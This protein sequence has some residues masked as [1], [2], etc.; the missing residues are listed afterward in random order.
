MQ[1]MVFIGTNKS[2]SSR[3]AIK[4]AE[5]LGYLTVLLTN[6]SKF[7]SQRKD[8]PDVHVMML[9][10]LTKE[11]VIQCMLELQHQGKQ[12]VAILSFLESYVRIAAEL[13]DEWKLSSF[14]TEAIKKMEDKI[15]THCVLQGVATS[16]FDVFHPEDSL[17]AFLKRHKEGKWIAKPPKST[18]SN[19]VMLANNQME[20]E[21]AII[22]ILKKHRGRPILV[23]EYLEGPQYLVETLI[24]E[25]R[26]HIVAIIKQE[27]SEYNPFV[28]TGY[29][30]QPQLGE[31]FCRSLYED[32]TSII[33]LFNI[34]EG[35]CHLELR[36]VKGKWK[37]IEVNPRI[38]GGA[39]NEMIKKAYGIDL[40]EQTIRLY[41]GQTPNLTRQWEEH[42]YTHYVTVE[43]SGNL[44][45]IT[46][47]KR[48]SRCPGVEKV[49]IK[50]K[51]GTFL[52]PP[53]SMGKRYAYV[54]AKGETAKEAK[55]NALNAAKE[56]YFHLE[57][58]EE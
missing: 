56:L 33:Q 50:P 7:L 36:L 21:N 54:M 23:E 16:T 14:S 25:G 4:A 57:K 10:D 39:M 40:V 45:K 9:S 37:L 1:T 34:K 2:G 41:L 55:V 22:E 38:S 29:S 24:H 47:R 35:A 13:S 5:R 49:H 48:A 52:Q 20:L 53:S 11:H 12:I 3:E 17:P 43:S 19:D 30:I 58:K 15:E 6:Q 18:G 27:F 42:I 8:F 28:I 44:I 51:K 46:G 31:G 26:V 32:I